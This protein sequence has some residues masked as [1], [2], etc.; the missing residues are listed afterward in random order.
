MRGPYR[1]EEDDGTVIF[2][3]K[4]GDWVRSN[5]Y[6]EFWKITSRCLQSCVLPWPHDNYYRVPSYGVASYTLSEGKMPEQGMRNCA[7]Q[8]ALEKDIRPLTDPKDILLCR[9]SDLKAAHYELAKQ[10]KKLDEDF[11]AIMRA[12]ELLNGK[13]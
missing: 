2:K 12:R 7:D 6:G 5:S 1:F 10:V 4:V 3:Y 9:A 11:D 13:D 8:D